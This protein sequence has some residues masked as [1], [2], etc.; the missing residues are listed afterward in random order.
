MGVWFL[1]MRFEVGMFEEVAWLVIMPLSWYDCGIC[2]L[3]LY[4]KADPVNIARK[5]ATLTFRKHKRICD[6]GDETNPQGVV[7]FT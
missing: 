2:L 4:R 7:K 3:N 6:F 1:V 5:V